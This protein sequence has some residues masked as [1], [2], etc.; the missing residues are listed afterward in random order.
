MLLDRYGQSNKFWKKS[1]KKS[2]DIQVWILWKSSRRCSES[3]LGTSWINLPW[4]SLQ[5]Q[6]LDVISGHPQD[7]RLGRPRDVRSGRP[8]DG[9]IESLGDV[10]KTLQGDVLDT[11]WGPVFAGWVVSWLDS[12]K[13]LN[14]NRSFLQRVDVLKHSDHKRNQNLTI[15]NAPVHLSDIAN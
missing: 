10:L 8:R 14:V 9:Q 5:H 2:W 11:S 4:M 12:K 15:V 6:T 1:W 7:V 3:V 13:Q